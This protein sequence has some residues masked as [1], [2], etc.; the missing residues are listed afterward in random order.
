MNPVQQIN[1]LGQSIWYDNI[2]RALIEMGDLQKLLDKGVTGVT[3]NPTIFE[4]AIAGS[5]DYDADI[6]RFSNEGKSAQEIYE[7][8]ATADIARGADLLRPVFEKTNHMDGYISLEVSPTLAHD[9]AGTVAEGKRLFALLARPNVMIK[10]PA[11]PAGIPAIRA[12]IGAGVNVNVTLIFGL[13]QYEPVAEAYL[14]GLEDL[15]AAGGDL[16][17]VA[18][19]AS[20]FISR[21]DAVVDKALTD[22][23]LQGKAAIAN[24]KVAYARFK[25]IFSGARWRKLAQAGARVQRPLWASTGTKNP[26]YADTLYIDNLIGPDTVNT[27]PPATLNAIFDHGN[28]ALTIETDVK[29]ARATLAQ[30]AKL[31]ID[32]DTIAQTLQD[33]GVVSFAKSFETLMASIAEK[34]E[35][36]GMA[37][38]MFSA[39]LGT[40]TASVENAYA[41]LTKHEV[42]TRIWAHDYTVWKPEPTEITN[43]LG[44]LHSPDVM[45]DAIP[46]IQALVNAVRGEGF[47]RAVLLGMGGS[48]LAPEVFRLTF[49]VQ[50]GYLDLLVLDSTHP[51]AVLALADQL[52][53]AKTLFIVSTKSGGTVETFS[54]FKYFYNRVLAVVGT[55]KVGQHFVAITDPGSGL[56][57]TATTY[58]FRKTFINDP[59]IG[60]RYSALS[61]F[62]LV[63]AALIGVDLKQ[64]LERAQTAACNADGSNCPW[65]GDNIAG[66][67]GALMGELT[68]Q[69]RD[70]VTIVASPQVASFGAWAE[71]LIAESTGKD[72]RGI[73]PVA[74]ESLGVAE[75]YSPDR[76]FVHLQMN[77]DTTY[78]MALEA[79]ANAGH[80]VVR[81]HLRD[82]YDIGAQFFYWEMATTIAGRRIGINP[83]DQ[84]NVESAK[85]LARQMVATYQH[86]GV[87]PVLTPTLERDGVAV[88]A[89]VIADTPVQALLDFLAQAKP[90]DYVTI[91]AYLQPTHQTTQALHALRM[92]IRDRYHM[93]TTVGYGPRFLHSTGQLHKGDSGNGLFI[94]FVNNPAQD[95]A[96]PNEAGDAASGISFGTL[97]KAQSLGDR[98]ALL[99]SNRRVIR[100]DL[101]SDVTGVLWQLAGL[102]NAGGEVM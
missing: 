82:A 29:L 100:F 79:L 14:A 31:G 89:D 58:Q 66:R 91:Q 68:V 24:A 48:S 27:V 101:G 86:E 41:E 30:L 92:H 46:D 59:N 37:H 102:G 32:M 40:Y 70:K 64:L 20:F 39:K 55:V 18:S 13:Q 76:L 96:I 45:M 98:Q 25:E 50:E 88:Y 99:N 4:K 87:L 85:I 53:Y 56:Q 81:L 65:H 23:A 3:S 62:G 78:D 94:Q 9:T 73:L 71:Q 67:L 63:P 74:D 61:F 35:R 90:G 33:E 93:A 75:Q 34:R 95:C 26:N 17:Q 6:Q 21:V 2:R 43:R 72:G 11:T 16:K 97:I 28:A 36:L 47:T 38:A 15:K 57:D 77:D 51:D 5:M 12:L 1:S 49:G 83:F 19:V 10:V 7:V 84:P 44:W 42:I 69:G 8:L 52:D 60:G 22:V 54:F 80:P